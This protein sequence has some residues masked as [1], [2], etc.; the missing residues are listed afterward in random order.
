MPESE[1]GCTGASWATCNAGD[2]DD[3][4][5]GDRSSRQAF[6]NSSRYTVNDGEWQSLC[7]WLVV[8]PLVV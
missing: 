2:G 6:S 8:R 3:G 7:G 4:D 5:D 1:S